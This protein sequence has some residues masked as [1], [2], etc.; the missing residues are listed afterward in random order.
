MAVAGDSKKM[1]FWGEEGRDENDVSEMLY[2]VIFLY[3]ILLYILDIFGK[4]KL[5]A[6]LRSRI[7]RKNCDVISKLNSTVFCNVS[8]LPVDTI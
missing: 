4:G 3:P 7:Q 6:G 1:F 5:N 8:T 2:R